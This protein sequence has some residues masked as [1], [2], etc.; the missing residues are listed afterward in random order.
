MTT[1]GS[2]NAR[3]RSRAK[4]RRDFS[5]DQPDLF[6]QL[7]AQPVPDPESIGDPVDLDMRM[8][9]LGAIS[10]ALRQARSRGLS[11][12]RVIER[13]NLLLPD[14]ERPLTVRQLNSW[15]ATSREHHPFPAWALPAFCAAVGNDLPLR[16]LAQAID[17]D[18]IDAREAVAKRLG[19]SRI[20]EARLRREQ[21]EL[22]RRLGA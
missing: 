6:Q 12:E 22:S 13:M 9:L 19:E 20:E 18:L 4:S 11:R 8:E 14:L 16:V 17:L 21:R 15:C 3:R 2:H 1:V 10:T 7:D 5:G